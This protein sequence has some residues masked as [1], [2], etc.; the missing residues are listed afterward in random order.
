MR[1][2]FALLWER[3][4]GQEQLGKDEVECGWPELITALCSLAS[5]RN[6]PCW[7]PLLHRCWTA[8]FSARV[9]SISLAMSW[10]CSIFYHLPVICHLFPTATLWMLKEHKEIL[11]NNCL[12]LPFSICSLSHYLQILLED[13][14]N[15]CLHSFL[16]QHFAEVHYLLTV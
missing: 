14:N 5:H 16:Q 12:P 2:V 7:D 9:N 4:D 3:A 13:T 8:T 1:E 6:T 10:A 11:E 15:I